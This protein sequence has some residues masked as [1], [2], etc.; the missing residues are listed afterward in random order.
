[1]ENPVGVYRCPVYK[2]LTRRGTL[3]TT[4]HRSVPA[5]APVA[6]ARNMCI[7]PAPQL[8]NVFKRKPLTPRS[9]LV[10][11]CLLL[12]STNF[13]LFVELPSKAPPAKWIKAGVALFCA[14]KY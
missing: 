1:M 6:R 5:P 9:L 13:V 10:Y 2:I 12:S 3:S 11:V 4:G 14:L 8:R 7:R